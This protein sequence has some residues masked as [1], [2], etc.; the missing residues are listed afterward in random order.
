MGDDTS[1]AMKG[2]D[3]RQR[4]KVIHFVP[5][6]EFEKGTF[7]NDVA[8]IRVCEC[9]KIQMKKKTI[10]VSISTGISIICAIEIA[11]LR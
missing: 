2:S 1:V 3:T 7:K 10:S 4:R 6:P 8:V 9:E 11:I 5:H